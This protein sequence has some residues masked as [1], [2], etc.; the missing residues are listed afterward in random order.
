MLNK[1]ALKSS[2]TCLLRLLRRKLAKS[3]AA[4]SNPVVDLSKMLRLNQGGWCLISYCGGNRRRRNRRRRRRYRGLVQCTMEEIQTHIANTHWCRCTGA[5]WRRPILNASCCTW[6][7]SMTSLEVHR[8]SEAMGIPSNS[9]TSVLWA[10]VKKRQK[11]ILHSKLV[12]NWGKTLTNNIACDVIVLIRSFSI[13]LKRNEI[14]EIQHGN[15]KIH[16]NP[17]K[18]S[19][20]MYPQPSNGILLVSYKIMKK[21]SRFQWMEAV[22]FFESRLQTL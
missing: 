15:L 21:I 9:L 7:A 13:Y 22:K 3:F 12:L 1:T 8:I 10:E 18:V 19:R 4:A 14:I 5:P 16:E 17:M 2:T 6:C 11:S 20:I